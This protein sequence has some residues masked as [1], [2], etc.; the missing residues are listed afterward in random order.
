MWEVNVPMKRKDPQ[1]KSRTK[2]EKLRAPRTRGKNHAGQ[3]NGQFVMT[4]VE[5]G[6]S[7]TTHAGGAPRQ[8]Y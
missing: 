3:S 5:R 2:A 6:K 1:Q 4:L 7:Q 8:G